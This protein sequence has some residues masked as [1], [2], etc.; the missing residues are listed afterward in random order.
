MKK[1]LIQAN[2]NQTY[3][4]EGMSCASCAASSQ[5]VLS[6]MKGVEEANVNF[7]NKSA[8][9]MFDP[10][11]VN[12]RLMQTKLSKLGFNLLED[13]EKIRAEQ[14]AKAQVRLK[15]LQTKVIVGGVLSIGLM[16]LAM[17]FPDFPYANFIMFAMTIPVIGWIGQEFFVNAG[18]QLRA[19]LTNMD[20]LVA[21]GT[22]TAFLFSIF[23]TF[24]P[25]ILQR[26]GLE[27]H[28][29]YETAGVLI[30]LILL[31]RWL[32]E[33]AKRSTATSIEQLLQLRPATA[34]VM[35]NGKFQK[36]PLE[37]IQVNDQILVQPGGKIPVDGV[38][39]KGKASVNESMITGE[40]I[41]TEKNISDRVIAG[42]VN[43]MGILTIQAQSVGSQ[44]MLA[45]IVKMVEQAQ[46]SKAPIQ[47][48]VD[49]IAQVFVPVVIA[50]ALLTFGIWW[51]FTDITQAIVAAIT[52]LIIACPCAL[53]LATPTA[54]MVGMGLGAKRGI[55]IKN[56]EA[57]EAMHQMDTIV[58]DKTGTITEGKPK[59]T[60]LEWLQNLDDEERTISDIVALESFSEH[61]LSDAIIQHFEQ[62]PRGIHFIKDFENITGRGVRANV[63]EHNY[64]IGN[65]SLLINANIPLQ[66]TLQQYPRLETATVWVAR[67]GVPLAAFHIKDTIKATSAK[68]ITDLQA[69]GIEVHMLSGDRKESVQEVADEMKI[70]HYMASVLPE[71]KLGY[72]KNLQKEGKEVAMVGD[73]INDSPA[74][75]QAKVGIAM[76]QGTDIAIESADV[77]LLSGDLQQ[78]ADAVDLSRKTVATIR[79]NLFWAFIYNVLGIPIA[80]GVLF[81]FTGFLLNPMIAGAAMAFSS[82]SVVLN[83]LRLRQRMK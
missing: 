9:I 78:L 21:L 6:R 41:P 8:Q 72:I 50:I 13:T 83:S 64:L 80:A 11:Q 4:I 39:V 35:K 26:Q 67:N 57:L 3:K 17:I 44:T 40:P 12:F 46:G 15:E 22:G 71:D 82:V 47:R 60:Q 55:L 61:P 51:Y 16:L 24:F 54:I 38:V 42:T 66:N 53:G 79:Q 20:T 33:R 73:G 27:P 1:Q 18:Q 70:Q 49:K 56:A 63:R 37:N 52:V 2:T 45:R 5:R 31:G 59:V 32:E 34:L 48:L 77:T 30:T 19:G 25:E 29:Y 81:P 69:L 74:L 23:N 36:T 76:G 10:N 14:A 62:S 75:A 58:L 65:Q 7:A 43:Q 28:V 68:A